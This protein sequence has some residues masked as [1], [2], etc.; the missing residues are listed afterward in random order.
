MVEE[1][2][3]ETQPQVRHKVFNNWEVIPKGWYYLFK[4]AEVS[5]GQVKSVFVGQQKLV[6]FRGESGAVKVL[7]S[8]CPHMGADL[9]IG[10]VMGDNL[11]CF[12]S[13]LAI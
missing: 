8:F 9:K 6:V 7:D 10:T 1:Y 11:R 4:S 13:P 3:L 12:F 2:N 5:K